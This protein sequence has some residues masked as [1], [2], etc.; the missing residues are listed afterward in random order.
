MVKG[1]GNK[2]DHNME[3]VTDANS[4][5][6]CIGNNIVLL[7]EI[8]RQKDFHFKEILLKIRVGNIDKQV[9]S[10]LSQHMKKE[11]NKKLKK[12]EIQPTRL[13]CL[14]KY[15]QDLNDSELKKLEDSGKKFINFKCSGLK[16]IQKK[17]S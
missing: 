16:N 2:N 4:W 3:F 10:V 1:A 7:T 6:K 13:F 9:R 17:Q 12:E 5:K 14:K 11:N 15:V 8:M